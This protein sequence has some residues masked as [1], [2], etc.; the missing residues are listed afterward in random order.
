M[1]LL[2][3]ISHMVKLLK[4]IVMA[5]NNHQTNNVPDSLFVLIAKTVYLQARQ[6]VIDDLTSMLPENWYGIDS[7]HTFANFLGE[8]YDKRPTITE[9]RFS[10][11]EATL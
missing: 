9:F 6:A 8:W 2:F 3:V 5:E 7:V 10:V 1:G 4:Q 11:S